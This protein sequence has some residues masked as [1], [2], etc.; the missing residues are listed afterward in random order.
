MRCKNCG[1]EIEENKVFC[2]ECENQMKRMSSREEVRELEQLIEEQKNINGLE[3]TRE[4]PDL[5]SLKEEEKIENI[6]QDN[7]ESDIEKTQIIAKSDIEEKHNDVV[8]DEEQ[9]KD[10]E[11][12]PKNNKKIIIILISIIA[13]IFIALVVVLILLFT[14]K[15]SDDTDKKVNKTKEKI[16]YEVVINDYGK[17]LETIVKE[18]IDKNNQIPTWQQVS[19]LN[20]YDKYEVV[21]EIHDIYDDGKVYLNSCKVNNKETKYSYGELQEEKEGKKITI[22]RYDEETMGGKFQVYTNENTSGSV[23]VGVITCKTENCEYKNAYQKY[24]VVK[25]ENKYYIYNYEKD[26][27]EFGPFNV[28]DESN[29]SSSVIAGYDNVLY[30]I[31][32]NEDNSYNMYSLLVGKTFK[33]VKGKLSSINSSASRIYKYGY[34]IFENNNKYNFVNLK[35][36]N[37]SYTIDGILN[38]SSFVEDTK[39]NIVY[40]LSYTNNNS[41]EFKIYNSNGK[42]LFNGNK[43]KNIS[44]LENSL[45]VSTG[46][47]YQIYDSNLKLKTSSKKYNKILNFYSDFI[48]VVNTD[49]N[50]EIVDTSDKELATFDLVWDDSRYKFHQLISGWYDKDGKHGI[51]LVVEDTTIPYGTDGSGLEYYYIPSTKETGVIQTKGVGGYAKPVLYL[52]PSK[53]T[54]VTVTF[55]NPNLLTTTYPKFNNNWNVTA[56]PN[57]DL[58]DKKGNYYYALYWEEEKNHNVDFSEGFYVTKENAIQFLEEKLS[59]IGLNAKERN[60]FIMYWLPVLEKNNKSLVYF[61]LTNERDSYN[62]LI[63]N[64]KPDSVL[65]IAMHVKKV[66]K[67]TSIKKQKL[68]T[69]KRNGFTVV[70][71]G[72]VIY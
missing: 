46:T 14:N 45:M 24:A 40:I 50:L 60:E 68:T 38:Q 62:K 29:L 9:K 58:Y 47:T 10:E 42:L 26:S 7:T 66:N 71:W 30:G 11:K 28:I 32:Y 2:T 69:F 49:N 34:V 52:Y 72:G 61:E 6:T 67:K 21:C 55:A 31:Y 13:I 1:K 25:E 19:E 54:N 44:I 18:Y 16:D 23:Q 64:P 22:Y 63:I 59:I 35:T 53:K 48:V 20:T 70:E 27:L 12:K 37:V 43:Y 57:G 5:N 36:G 33:N 65:R 15:K 51:Y 3:V 17:S 4:L 56:Y 39:N 8:N 41:D